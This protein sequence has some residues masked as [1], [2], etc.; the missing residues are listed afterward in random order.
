MASIVAI[1]EFIVILAQVVQDLWS[2]PLGDAIR[3]LLDKKNM[4]L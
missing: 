4:T 2:G 3:R 1:L